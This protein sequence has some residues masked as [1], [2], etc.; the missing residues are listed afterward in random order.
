ML[1]VVLRRGS[2]RGAVQERLMHDAEWSLRSTGSNSRRL[3]CFIGFAT[4]KWGGGKKR[5]WRVGGISRLTSLGLFLKLLPHMI[6]IGVS[7]DQHVWKAPP[8]RRSR[9]AAA[10]Q[11]RRHDLV[12]TRFTDHSGLGARGEK[13][14]Q[15]AV[16]AQQCG[17]NV[18]MER[19]KKY[20]RCLGLLQMTGPSSS[21]GEP[22]VLQ[23]CERTAR[24]ASHL[25]FVVLMCAWFCCALLCVKAL[26]C[27]GRDQISGRQGTDQRERK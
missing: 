14:A 19:D 13:A 11:M 1:P 15:S 23:F 25:L 20:L 12:R 22:R 24:A 17:H 3:G 16:R 27:G 5:G 26:V 9:P 10:H 8:P 6:D 4:E 7:I 2:E 21:K 18:R